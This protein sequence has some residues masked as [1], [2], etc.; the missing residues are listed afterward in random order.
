[1]LTIRIKSKKQEII[2]KEKLHRTKNPNKYKAQRLKILCNIIQT[3]EKERSIRIAHFF[4]IL[5]SQSILVN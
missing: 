5:R 1:M 2:T 4:R 3:I